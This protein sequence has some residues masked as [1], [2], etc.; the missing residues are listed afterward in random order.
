LFIK[1]FSEINTCDIAKID[2]RIIG[3]IEEYI[4]IAERSEISKNLSEDI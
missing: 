4:R 1:G 2:T 3:A